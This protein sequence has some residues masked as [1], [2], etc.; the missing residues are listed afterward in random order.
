VTEF[1]S[2]R[3]RVIVSF[4]KPR[5]GIA[6]CIRQSTSYVVVELRKAALGGARGSRIAV[7]AHARS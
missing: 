6:T 3:R 7:V 5:I 4:K 1:S 2:D